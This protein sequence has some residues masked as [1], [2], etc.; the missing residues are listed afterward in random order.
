LIIIDIDND[1]INIPEEIQLID[2]PSTNLNSLKEKLSNVDF[3]SLQTK[4]ILSP[5]I[6]N[7]ESIE[8]FQRRIIY[9]LNSE[10]SN[11]FIEF[12]VNLFG[13]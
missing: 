10:I 9:D 2:F 12:Y 6:M 4:L 13:Y 8:E 1:R 5:V 7:F 3:N 11:I